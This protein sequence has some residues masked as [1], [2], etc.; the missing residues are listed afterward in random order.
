MDNIQFEKIDYRTKPCHLLTEEEIKKFKELFDNHYGVWASEGTKADKAGERIRFPLRN[1]QKYCKL[2]NAYVAYASIEDTVIGHAFYIRESF[3]DNKTISWVLQLVVHEQYRLHGV[4]K[5]LLYSIWGFSEDYGW[6]L[7]TS[8]AL[9]VKTLERA[10]FRKVRTDVMKRHE[11]DIIMIKEKVPFAKDVAMT[12]DSNSSVLDSSFPVD[13]KTIQENLRLYNGEWRL[14]NLP[15]GCEWVA[16]TF[17]DQAFELDSERFNELFRNSERIVKDAYGRMELEDQKWNKHHPAEVDFIIKQIDSTSP[18]YV[19]DFGCGNGRHA[20]EFAKRGYQVTG[21]DYSEKNIDR[22]RSKECCG[23]EFIVGDCRYI[24]IDKKADLALCLYDVVGSYT[25][26]EDNFKIVC[27][28]FKHLKN[29]AYLFLSVLNLE[30][31]SSIAVHK[32]NE[33]SQNPEQLLNLRPSNTMKESGNIFLPEYFL[34]ETDTGIVYRK[35]QFENDGQLSA[36]YVIRDKRYS[37]NEISNM[38]AKAGFNIKEIRYVQAGRWD[39]SLEPTD[40]KAK[41]ILVIAC[42]E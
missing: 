14:G 6:G 16:F 22:V 15:V 39:K 1:Y 23:A 36:E 35:E 38:L 10:T 25:T 11:N 24:S 4:A 20:I 9:T 12:L 8:N 29:G 13:Q 40:A 34:L 30:L 33:I 7:A 19:M 32:T 28:I 41:E 18:M 2:D 21:I 3:P 26:Y 27:N 17:R 5:T 42:K 37:G 31:T